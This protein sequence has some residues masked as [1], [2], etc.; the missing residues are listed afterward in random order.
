[1]ISQIKKWIPLHKLLAAYCLFTIFLSFSPRIMLLNEWVFYIPKLI[2]LST[3][4][5]W[6]FLTKHL[7]LKGLR[8]L[9]AILGIGFLGFF[10]NETG[11]LNHLFFRPIDP[12]LISLEEWLFGLQPSIWLS[13]KYTGLIITELMNMGYLSYYFILIGFVLTS[14][15]RKP[16]QFDYLL[17]ILSHSFIV[18]YLIFIFIPSWGPQFYFTSPDNQAP[19]GIFFQKIIAFIQ[20][21]GEATTGAI[22]SSHVGIT[23]IV[24]LLAYR[25]FRNFFWGILPFAL[26][27]ICS[28]VYIKAHYFVDVIAGIISAPPILF[29]SQKTWKLLNKPSYN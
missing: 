25:N 5:S 12:F 15:Y 3:I 11:Q 18:Y 6:F 24:L 14:L 2:I 28:T 23:I 29:L 13:S 19:N 4:F 17:F 7:S 16:D 1:M 22:P 27:L 10:Y 8:Y 21:N 26:I 20:M 9:N